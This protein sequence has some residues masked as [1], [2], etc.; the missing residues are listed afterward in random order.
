MR[1]LISL[2]SVYLGSL[3]MVLSIK[4]DQFLDLVEKRS[5]DK[6]TVLSLFVIDD[7]KINQL[8]QVQSTI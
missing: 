4:N 1:Q 7:E 8:N 5:Y 2:P 6:G 3:L